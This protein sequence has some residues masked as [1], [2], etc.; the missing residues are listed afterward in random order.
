MRRKIRS[1][2]YNNI[3]NSRET[4]LEIRALN[5]KTLKKCQASVSSVNRISIS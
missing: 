2:L 1:E 4:I 5:K 3:F